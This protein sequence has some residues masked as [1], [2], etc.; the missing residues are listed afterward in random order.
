MTVKE[1]R[2]FLRHHHIRS[3]VFLLQSNSD[4]PLSDAVEIKKVI[5]IEDDRGN[6]YVVLVPN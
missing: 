3:R 6:E 5:G 4:N 1:L 2:N